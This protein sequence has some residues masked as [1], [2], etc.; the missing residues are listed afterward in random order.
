M[1]YPPLNG[2]TWV[3]VALWCTAKRD[4]SERRPVRKI[5][6]SGLLALIAVALAGA[7][8]LP[9]AAAS[10]TPLAPLRRQRVPPVPHSSSAARSRAARRAPAWR[11]LRTAASRAAWPRSS[12]HGTE[13]PGGSVPGAE[14]RR[15]PTSSLPTMF[16]PVGHSRAWWLGAYLPGADAGPDQ[17]YAL[18]WNGASLTP[19]AAPPA[20]KGRPPRVP[21]AGV[22]CVSVR[23]CV[24][25]RLPGGPGCSPIVV[26]TWNGAKWTLQH[27][28]GSAARGA[29]RRTP[30]PCPLAWSVTSCVVAGEALPGR[31][32]G[33]KMFLARWNGTSASR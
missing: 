28:R 2:A 30:A 14:S 11:S 31:G 27:G 25:G 29:V 10:A 3:L 18:T 33:A 13:R 21:D 32:R 16:L 24:A 9:A 5:V 20:P 22:S 6:I 8:A 15:S 19:T 23:S 1:R 17:P 12:R 7:N 26:E 4:L